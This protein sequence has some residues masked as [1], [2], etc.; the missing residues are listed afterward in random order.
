MRS[1]LTSSIAIAA[2]H[3]EVP[4]DI[5]Q[6]LRDSFTNLARIGYSLLDPTN[7][8]IISANNAIIT[9]DPENRIIDESDTAYDVLLNIEVTPNNFKVDYLDVA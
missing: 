4:K 7:G 2:I 8:K 3:R 1:Q 5:Q 9:T 6:L